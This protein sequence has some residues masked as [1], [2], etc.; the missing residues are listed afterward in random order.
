[1]AKLD[2]IITLYTSERYDEEAAQNKRA[3]LRDD[4]IL[5]TADKLAEQVMN[6]VQGLGYVAKVDTCRVT[7]EVG[8]KERAAPPEEPVKKQ[9]AG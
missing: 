5:P 3:R 1:M 7:Q 6:V 9:S 2:L 4:R 8:A